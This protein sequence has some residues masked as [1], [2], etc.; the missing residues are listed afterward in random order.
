MG[1]HRDFV[2][3][4]WRLRA[5]RD[6]RLMRHRHH[7]DITADDRLDV[8]DGQR[9]DDD[10][11]QLD[12]CCHDIARARYNVASDERGDDEHD[13]DPSDVSE[14]HDEASDEDDGGEQ[15]GTDRAAADEM[16]GDRWAML[17]V[18]VRSRKLRRIIKRQNANK[19][20]GHP[21]DWRQR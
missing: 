5:E 20:M 9:D 10:A 13:D 16:I 14:H 15:D 17:V 21:S 2:G 7:D 12:C 6:H 1:R 4:L 11:R 8:D 18:W 3:W 19:P